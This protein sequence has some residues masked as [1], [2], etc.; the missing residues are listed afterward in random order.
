MSAFGEIIN[1]ILEFVGDVLFEHIMLPI[2]KGIGTTTR[3]VLCLGQT[4]F[5]ELYKQDN[6]ALLGILVLVIVIISYIL[7]KIY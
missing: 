7:A 1:V 2:L 4:P 3:W 5:K 6:N